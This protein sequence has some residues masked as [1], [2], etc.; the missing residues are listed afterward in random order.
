MVRM[1]GQLRE[2]YRRLGEGGAEVAEQLNA[3]L[4]HSGCIEGLYAMVMKE[5]RN[6]DVDSVLGDLVAMATGL[7]WVR[8]MMGLTGHGQ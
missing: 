5:S 7:G 6:F 8:D 2:C 1:L 3:M 4:D